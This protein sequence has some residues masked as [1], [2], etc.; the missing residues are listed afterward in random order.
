MPT[1]ETDRPGSADLRRSQRRRKQVLRSAG[2]ACT[3]MLAVTD[4]SWR[5]GGIGTFVAWSG[6]GLILLCIL[7]RTWSAIYIGGQKQRA[8]V[9]EGPYSVV[10]NPLYV[11]TVLG[12]A[13][14]GAYSGSITIGALFAII[15]FA[16]F[17]FV[18]RQEERFLDS[19]FPGEY[20]AYVSRVPRFWPNFAL[21][22][23]AEV[24]QVRPRFVYQTFFEAILFLLAVPAVHLK[25]LAQAQE[26]LPRLLLLP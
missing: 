19:A 4:S 14:I 20:S 15:V 18:V 21:W 7:G 6:L 10:R 2:L 8:L 3:I 24:L 22:K 16:V 17:A 1:Y 13:G 12:A 25:E 23:D 26:L 5:A 11:F 9:T